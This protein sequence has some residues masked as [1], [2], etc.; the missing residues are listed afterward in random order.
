[1]NKPLSVLGWIFT[2]LLQGMIGYVLGILI[3]IIFSGPIAKGPTSLPFFEM[4]LGITLGIFGVGAIGLLFRKP[5]Q[6]KKYPVR[7][8]ITALG[9]CIPFALFRALFSSNYPGYVHGLINDILLLIITLAPL[10][11][12]PLAVVLG[13]IGFYIPSWFKDKSAQTKDG[14]KSAAG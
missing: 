4:W 11:S 10:M 6:F 14:I 12:V 2:I 5:I 13:I 9:A 7:L 8:V 3:M 1:M